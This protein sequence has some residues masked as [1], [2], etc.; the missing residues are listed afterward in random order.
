[1]EE[2]LSMSYNQAYPRDP[3]DPHG[4]RLFKF[5]SRLWVKKYFSHS[6]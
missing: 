2:S 5:N 3:R 4:S 1:M 6:A